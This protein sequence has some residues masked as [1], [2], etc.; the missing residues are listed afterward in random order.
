MLHDICN[1]TKLYA[2]KILFHVD[3][4]NNQ[5]IFLWVYLLCWSLALI[6]IVFFFIEFDCNVCCRCVGLS[7][8]QNVH[9]WGDM[10]NL[11]FLL[12]AAVILEL[13]GHICKVKYIASS[14]FFIFSFPLLF[15][16][17]HYLINHF[18]WVR[19][20][21]RYTLVLL[22]ILQMCILKYKWKNIN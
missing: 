8:K 21:Q 3:P 11:T 7:G 9:C 22:W 20:K 13:S 17:L 4:R 19:V 12:M 15:L 1:V 16:A 6:C 2:C 14:I 5:E 10:R 18:S